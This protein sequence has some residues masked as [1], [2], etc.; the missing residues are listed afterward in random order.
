MPGAY[1][2]VPSTGTTGDHT[3]RASA[4]DKTHV[5]SLPS[6]EINGTMP[7]DKVGGAGAL[8]G[9]INEE[10]VSQ[11]P[12][13]RNQTLG[14]PPA[15]YPAAAPSDVPLNAPVMSAAT[16]VVGA[17]TAF[18]P[19]EPSAPSAKDRDPH[20]ATTLRDSMPS[21]EPTGQQPYTHQDGVGSLPGTISEKSVIKLPEE[22]AV[23]SA[24]G[25][26]LPST[27]LRGQQ[28][29]EHQDGVGA[30]PGP[31]REQGVALLPDETGGPT[32]A[33]NATVNATGTRPRD[34]AEPAGV[35]R[36]GEEQGYERIGASE[37]RVGSDAVGG[38]GS[39]L[40]PAGGEGVSMLP[41]ERSRETKE[42]MPTAI[43]PGQDTTQGDKLNEM[44]GAERAERPE[45]K[46]NVVE[47]IHT[48]K[49]THTISG[50]YDTGYH[51]AAMHPLGTYVGDNAGEHEAKGAA[52]T[53]DAMSGAETKGD[54]MKDNKTE[55]GESVG[56]HG[57]EGAE[58]KTK[59]A[60]IM[61]K[62]KG[63]AKVLIGKI[64]GKK[65]V[66]KVKEGKMQKAGELPE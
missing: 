41:I 48:E 33:T 18:T 21:T 11:A 1:G 24:V 12:D 35:P 51:P 38:V 57:H 61:D 32:G 42:R 6:D 13:E 7:S 26:S 2:T 47:E 29:F 20:S 14:F 62:V 5:V 30:L 10:A 17:T 65:G 27:E 55:G 39:P 16:G 49:E 4:H 19:L 34:Y 28:P 50:G 63:E 15:P 66:E 44:D 64:E 3:A 43:A 25:M 60:G 53:G 23:G 9:S 59:K 56:T 52:T 8:P 37:R 36:L 40:G 22:A 58:H 54:A 46:E 45:R 31:K